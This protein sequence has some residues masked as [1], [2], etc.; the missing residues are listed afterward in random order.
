MDPSKFF[1]NCE[2]SW[3]RYSTESTKKDYIDP[4]KKHESYG[5]HNPQCRIDSVFCSKKMSPHDGLCFWHHARMA[6]IKPLSCGCQMNLV[7]CGDATGRWMFRNF[8]NVWE[9]PVSDCSGTLYC[10]GQ[11]QNSDTQSYVCGD[12]MVCQ[13]CSRKHNSK[14]LKE[15][16]CPDSE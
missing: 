5:K 6:W 7:C 13:E 16:I 11:T 12:M 8:Y 10:C 9:I 14:F 4:D 1:P 2:E 3:T 15:Y